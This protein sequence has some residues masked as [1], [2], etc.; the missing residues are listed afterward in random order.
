MGMKEKWTVALKGVLLPVDALVL[1]G[2]CS[3]SLSQ[4]Q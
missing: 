1:Q 4:L 2:G 3:S